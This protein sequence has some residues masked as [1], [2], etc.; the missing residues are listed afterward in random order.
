VSRTACAL[1]VAGSDPSGGAGIQADLRVFGALGVAGLSAIT[2][3]TVQNS[4]GVKAVHATPG[5]VLYDQ[6]A[7]VL[8]D[9]GIGAVK[10]GMLAGAE[11]VR[12][13]V[14]AL[15]RFRPPNIVLDPVLASTGGTPL[16]DDAG[17][18][19]LL[20]DLLPLCRLVTPN[21]PELELLS[22]VPSAD[23]PSRIRGAEALIARGALAVLV[24]G[25]H[26]AGAPL[27]LLI[28]PCR[29]AGDR[30]SA[31]VRRFT[32]ARVD[33]PHTH[34][35]GCFLSSAI[36]AN[37]ARGV[38]LAEAIESAKALLMLALERPQAPGSGPGWPDTIAAMREGLWMQ[39]S[40]AAHTDRIR[41]LRSG[42]YV[43]TSLQP[44][45]DRTADEVARQAIAGGATTIQLRDKRLPTP[46]LVSV[47][48]RLVAIC[49]EA[50][51]LLIV[52][53]RVDVVLAADADGVHLGPDD[54][55]PGDARRMLGPNRL[56]GVS[57]G[58]VEEAAVAAPYASYLG[59]GAIFGSTTKLDAGDAVGPGRI[60]EIR[61]ALGGAATPI[62]AIGGITVANI[63][64]AACAGAD[65]AAVVSAVI[66]A[67][68][69]AAATAALLANFQAG[70]GE[71]MQP[72]C[73]AS[74][75]GIR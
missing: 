44:R 15:R 57:T 75:G 70:S 74:P 33:T 9:C 50:G 56:I 16:L 68:D 71:P 10:I 66:G 35:T 19:L 65:A 7:A 2:A 53:D 12:A 47:A 34:G 11:Q 46:D 42:L 64:E 5:R 59:V 27:D 62:V 39:A 22:L 28:E 1:T 51:A 13:V 43:I 32:A 25:G 20:R 38:G 24:K 23:E 60:A 45:P 31:R 37:L 49:R 30:E 26:A 58:T 67:P 3:L 18:Q 63:G 17:K 6:I 54:M 8:E 69:M 61:R 14:E 55:R 41:L 40:G 21:I 4:H 36:A 72:R 29:D 52:N 48:K 73:Q